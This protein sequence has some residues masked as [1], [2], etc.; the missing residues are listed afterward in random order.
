MEGDLGTT[1][2]LKHLEALVW[3]QLR[4]AGKKKEKSYNVKSFAANNLNLL[5]LIKARGMLGLFFKFPDIFCIV[6]RIN[7]NFPDFF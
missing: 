5:F 1:Q 7:L 2:T 4:L 3:W 6:S